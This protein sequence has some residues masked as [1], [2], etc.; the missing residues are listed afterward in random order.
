MREVTM[1]SAAHEKPE[2]STESVMK[3]HCRNGQKMLDFKRAGATP[4]KN[5]ACAKFA[6]GRTSK[7]DERWS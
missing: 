1:A 3:R 6:L 7:S 4:Q 5:D 2:L